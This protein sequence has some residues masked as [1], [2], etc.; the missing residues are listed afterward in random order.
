MAALFTED[1]L[2]QNLMNILKSDWMKALVVAGL[3]M[4]IPIMALLDRIRQKIRVCTGLRSDGGKFTAEGQRVINE[5]SLWAWCS[6][7]FKVNLVGLLG[8]SLLLGMKLTY[9]F[10]LVA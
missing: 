4:F 7:F 9:V 6:I 8:I 1:R 5:M 3:N 2:A 10:L